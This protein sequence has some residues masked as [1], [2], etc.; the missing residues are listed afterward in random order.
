MVVDYTD[1]N[2]P[3]KLVQAGVIGLQTYGA[4]GH[5]GWVKFRDIHVRPL[6]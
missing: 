4:D 5:A 3:A 6:D 2:P 1:E